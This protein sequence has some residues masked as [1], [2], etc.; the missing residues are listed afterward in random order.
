MIKLLDVL[1]ISDKELSAYKVHFAMDDK[2]KM[3]PFNKYLLGEFK[4]WQEHQTNKNF[5]RKYIL[6]L[7]Y[8]GK[9]KWLFG[10]VYEVLSNKPVEVLIDNWSG[11]KYETKLVDNQTDLI[12]RL[13]VYYKKDYRASYPNL[14]LEPSNK[15]SMKPRDMYVTSIS[16]QKSSINDFSGFDNVNIDYEILKKIVSEEIV[17]WKSALSNVKGIYLIADKKTGKQYVGS[18][19]GDE[20]IWQRW[21]TYAKGGHGDN[22]KLKELLKNHGEDYKYNFKYSILE[23]CNMNLGAEYILERENYWKDVLQTRR[24]GLNGN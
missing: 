3:K 16:E 11:W 24:F 13:I 8:Y 2:D 22:T 9:D 5:S 14:E 20:C 12:G 19:R 23:V 18:A 17:S 15:E 21:A 6:S 4:G 1:G 10:G 7:I